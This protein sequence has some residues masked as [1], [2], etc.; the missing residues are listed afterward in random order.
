LQTGAGPAQLHPA[1]AVVDFQRLSKGL[2]C[3]LA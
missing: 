1:M 2:A 3:C